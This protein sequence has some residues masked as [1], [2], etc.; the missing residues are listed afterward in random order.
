MSALFK[1]EVLLT[2]PQHTTFTYTHT[3]SLELGTI[4]EVSF[5]KQVVTGAVWQ[6]TDSAIQHPYALKPIQHVWNLPPLSDP[7]RKL[8]NWVADYYLFARGYYL[9]MVL[10][11]LPDVGYSPRKTYEPFLP[12]HNTTQ[13]VSLTPQQI[14]AANAIR[15][16]IH[17]REFK[18]FLLDGVTGSGKTEVYYEAVLEAIQ[19]QQQVLILLPEITLTQQWLDRFKQRFG[20]LP[21]R[22]HS[23]LK[24]TE[25][26][27]T[28][29]Q[30]I[31]G[32]A[33]VVVG[34]RSAL[35]LPF[36]NLGLIVVDEEHDGSY[37][38]D[39]GANYH[40]RD[41]AVLRAQFEKCPVVLAS[42]TPS[43]ESYTNT[44][45]H[46]YTLLE[47]SNR[48]GAA[49][50]P[51]AHVVDL[52]VKAENVHPNNHISTTLHSAIEATLTRKEQAIL[53]LNR[54]GFAP[55]TLCTECGHKVSCPNCT[56]NMVLHQHNPHHD[57]H[58]QCHH[59]G[60]KTVTP[61]SC[62]ECHEP[63]TLHAWGIGI[64]KLSQ[65]VAQHFP[66]ARILTVSSD[67][68]TNQSDLETLY[69]ALK[70]HEVDIVI[71]TQ[72]M[73]KGHDFSNVTLVGIVD[74]D[75]SLMNEDIRAGETTYQLLHQVA[76]RCG[77]G[78]K[79]GNV[80]IQTFSPTHPV[81]E[82]LQTFN[83]DAFLNLEL[84]NRQAGM[85]P[86]FGRQAAIVVSSPSESLANETCLNLLKRAP[87]DAHLLILGPAPAPIYKLRNNFRFRFLLQSPKELKLQPYLTQWLS[88][89]AIPNKVKV[90]VDV[91][92]IHFF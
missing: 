62:P 84:S 85:L 69:T 78:D 13:L 27:H 68:V 10:T 20:V 39:E 16:S 19:H 53:F 73:A 8:I 75:S 80:Y 34:A 56:F 21:A 54:R 58:L 32:N 43:V 91:D 65:Q 1:Y 26:L 40:A 83:R 28:W 24:Q 2:L 18:P 77:R 46:K 51:K 33:P 72:I 30:I 60:L 79:P 52:R 15:S 4:V 22:W 88:S 67:H 59:C 76:G 61:K 44:L 70:N 90:T 11:G 92:P 57:G 31:Q 41:I 37:K 42:A 49:G 74:A 7:L 3:A 45:N 36:Q 25:R 17:A 9:K 66:T 64:Q 29:H 81:I 86:P 12:P 5:G 35:F 48:F 87:Q 55:V 82:A 38:Q 71:G 47:L 23:A 14:S 6:L 63:N 50:T 89:V